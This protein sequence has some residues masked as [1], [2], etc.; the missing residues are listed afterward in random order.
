LD[1]PLYINKINL[2]CQPSLLHTELNL[3]LN[4]VRI[5]QAAFSRQC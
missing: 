1:T 5:T 2:T 3:F 4:N